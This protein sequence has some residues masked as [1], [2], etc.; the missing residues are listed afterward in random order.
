MNYSRRIEK[1][2]KKAPRQHGE[3]WAELLDRLGLRCFKKNIQTA[4]TFRDVVVD[5]GEKK[6]WRR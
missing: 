4:E 3:T 5:K 1:I 2:E 6:V